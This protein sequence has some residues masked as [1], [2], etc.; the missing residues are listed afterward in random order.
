M[1]WN[2]KRKPRRWD[3]RTQS[4]FLVV[5]LCV[6]GEWRWLERAEWVEEFHQDAFGG[7]W[8]P[9]E[10]LAASPLRGAE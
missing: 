10:W 2:E 4:A 7:Y 5:P 1:R 6:Q 9:V 8:E 3:R